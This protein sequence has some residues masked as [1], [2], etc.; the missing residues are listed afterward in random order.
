MAGVDEGA[1]SPAHGCEVVFID[2]KRAEP[3]RR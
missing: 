1:K 3:E 2:A